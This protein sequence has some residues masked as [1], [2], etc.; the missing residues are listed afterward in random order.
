[1]KILILI[2]L[3]LF[4]ASLIR[5]QTFA[6]EVVKVLDGDTIQIKHADGNLDR[7]RLV[8]LDAP[9]VA[10]NSKQ[11][12]QPFG[13]ECQK[14]LFDFVSGQTVSIVGGARDLHG[15]ILA[16]VITGD[17]ADVNL[18]I[19]Q[20]GCGWIYYPQ[21]IPP[22]VRASYQTAFDAA[23][24]ARAGLFANPKAV[25]PSAWR[26]ARAKAKRRAAKAKK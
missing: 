7:V 5:A 16:R 26:P 23:R 14:M 8:G 6:A 3:I 24:A 15:R 1:M 17:G 2:T 12:P 25:A 20:N 22:A 21:N 11:K 13:V 10:H 9:E 4:A 18:K 19:L